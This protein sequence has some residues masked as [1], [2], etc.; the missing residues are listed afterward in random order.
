MP[1]LGSR[2]PAFRRSFAIPGLAAVGAVVLL[3]A[4]YF[5]AL[6]IA[7]DSNRDFLAID[8]C[9]DAGGAWDYSER[10]CIGAR[11]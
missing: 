1:G 5:G 2:R 10:E 8:G 3:L 11:E 6:W 7:H 9:L 4:V